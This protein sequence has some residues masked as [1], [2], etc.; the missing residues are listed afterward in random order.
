MSKQGFTD[1]VT[2]GIVSL[3]Q[4]L[5]VMLKVVDDP[6][7]TDQGRQLAAGA[8]LSVLSGT[9]HI[10]GMRGILAYVDDVLVLR[11][12][13]ERIAKDSADAIAKYAGESPDFI[14]ALASD[15]ASARAFLGE[16]TG[17]L[18]RAVD[19]LGSFSHQGHSATQCAKDV[20]AGTWLYDEVHGALVESFEFDE[21]EVVREVRG[22]DRIV[23]A[24]RS[25]V[26]VQP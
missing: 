13:I 19:K 18:E 12:V 25:R 21:D 10:P 20:E 5:K 2:R 8:L 7:I 23:P 15:L 1:F 6:G 9:N 4:D 16:L 26:G 11:L 3:P 24:L 22:I 17:V 14:G